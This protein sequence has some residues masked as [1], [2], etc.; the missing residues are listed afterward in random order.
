MFAAIEREENGGMVWKHGSPYLYPVHEFFQLK[1]IV[2][3]TL[4]VIEDIRQK[5]AKPPKADRPELPDELKQK[6]MLNARSFHQAMSSKKV[7]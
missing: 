5:D 7:G 2:R 6:R 1:T 3:V 4:D